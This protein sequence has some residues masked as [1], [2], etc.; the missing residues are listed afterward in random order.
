MY[1]KKLSKQ[2]VCTYDEPL[3]NTKY[4]TLRGL[5]HDSV[6]L[7]RG[8]QYAQARRFHF[9]EEPES[10]QGV[11]EAFQFG[12]VC[13][14]LNT[15]V[16]HDQYTVPHFFYPQN[17]HCQYLNIWTKHLE[18]E[19]KKPVMIWIHGG[20]WFSGSS[21]E[22]LAYDGENL[23]DRDDVVVVSLNH[24]LNVLGY[25]DLSEYGEEYKNSA[26]AGLADLVMALKWVNENI[27]AFGGD[28]DN[29]TIFGQS[30]GGDKVVSLMQTPSADG[31]FHKAIIQSGGTSGKGIENI[32]KATEVNKRC[33]EL[34]LEYLNINKDNV[35]EIENVDWYDLAQA[36]MNAVWVIQNCEGGQVMWGPKPDGEYF[37]GHPLDYGFRKETTEIPMLVGSVLGEFSENFNDRERTGCKNK[38]DDSTREKYIS[39]MF[40][41]NADYMKEL[42]ASGYGDRNPA[43][44]LYLDTRL[45]RGCISFCKERAKAGGTCYNWLFNLESPFNYGTV[46]WHNAEEPFVFR[47]SAYIEAQYIPEVC[48]RLEDQMA[49]AWVT[50][51]KTGN[52]NFELIPDWPAC[53][54]DSL[55]TMCFDAVTEVRTDHDA[56]LMRL[57]PDPAFKGFPGS[58]KMFAMFGVEPEKSN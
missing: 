58:G 9:P 39:E 11:K 28:P 37:M 38:W 7:F 35:R 26:N 23:C 4:G 33:A 18:R 41:D 40:G 57:Y 19:A 14:E 3:A 52:P 48:E 46:P 10:W 30:G 21:V 15:P 22:L 5:K 36:T 34:I 12:Y 24:R 44:I 56:E 17:E 6:Y 20:G 27:S 8:I 13:C 50:F 47:N 31:L 53:E 42:F 29:V 16:P 51:A 2:V 49:G 32:K 43:D 54:K 1:M 25:L 45:R 55:P